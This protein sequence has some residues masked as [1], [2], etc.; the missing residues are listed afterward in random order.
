[1]VVETFE[2]CLSIHWLNFG[3][4]KMATKKTIDITF[5]VFCVGSNMPGY[6]PD[7]PPHPHASFED[8]RG[9]MLWDIGRDI[10]DAVESAS[11]DVSD[12]DERLLAAA[13]VAELERFAEYCKNCEADD[14]GGTVG[15]R[16]YF[17]AEDTMTGQEL[18]DCD[19]DPSDYEPILDEWIDADELEALEAYNIDITI[20]EA[21]YQ[22]A[23]D[24]DVHTIKADDIVDDYGQGGRWFVGKFECGPWVLPSKLVRADSWENAWEAYIDECPTVPAD[25][26]H[27]AYDIDDQDEFDRMVADARDGLCEWPELSG[28]YS[29]QSNSTDTGIVYSADRTLY[30]VGSGHNLVRFKV[31]ID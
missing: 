4:T 29:L 15:N 12:T 5:R 19:C 3:E 6:M 20:I 7:E 13:H 2:G 21:E 26:L 22:Y 31:R 14:I 9:S 23:P 25:E 10:D 16:H 18:E 8:A 1:M 17:I 11:D 27:E 28:E 24:S 30:S